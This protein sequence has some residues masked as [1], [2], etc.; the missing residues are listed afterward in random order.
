MPDV[1]IQYEDV[2]FGAT[3]RL[4][5]CELG[6]AQLAALN[7]EV[8]KM[9][10]RGVR[11]ITAVYLTRDDGQEQSADGKFFACVR[12]M[13]DTGSLDPWNV[14]PPTALLKQAIARLDP[15]VEASLEGNWEVS[16]VAEVED[17]VR[18]TGRRPRRA[19]AG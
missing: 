7:R 9:L 13:T 4:H 14:E 11:S 17:Q 18:N 3:S 15:V 1:E 6:A 5:D 10:P 8:Q 16:D 2:G 12:I 19:R